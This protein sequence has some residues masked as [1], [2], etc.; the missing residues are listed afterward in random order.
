MRDFLVTVE[1]S[2]KKKKKAVKDGKQSVKHPQTQVSVP[3]E[4]KVLS[5]EE[6]KAVDKM[7]KRPFT[8]C[9][10]FLR[11]LEPFASWTLPK[12]TNAP[13]RQHVTRRGRK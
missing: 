5:P 1:P 2:K 12:G 11:F 13:S 7:K 8:H 4:R 9:E 3:E 10:Y 6:Q